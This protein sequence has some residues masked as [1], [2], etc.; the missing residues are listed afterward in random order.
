M[1]L[2]YL[3]INET[4]YFQ[5]NPSDIS[6]ASVNQDDKVAGETSSIAEKSNDKHEASQLTTVYRSKAAKEI[7]EELVSNVNRKSE[8]GRRVMSKEK[9]R[10]HTI[11]HNKPIL[12]IDNASLVRKIWPK[13]FAMTAQ[14]FNF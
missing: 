10:H 1:Y 6:R 13:I 9:R 8:S 12:P 11:S 3:P 4:I 5:S 7:V 14:P 2:A